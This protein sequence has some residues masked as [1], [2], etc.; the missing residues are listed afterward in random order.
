ME[1]SFWK[2]RWDAGQIGFH[3]GTANRFLVRFADRLVDRLAEGSVFVPLA[4]KTF[5][6]DHLL[7]KGHAVTAVELIEA[8]VTAFFEERKLAPKI[9]READRE[10]HEHEGLT[11]IRGDV[12][13]VRGSFDAVWD[14][15][16]LIA[17]P[18]DVRARYAKHVTSLVRPG[19]TMLLV[20]LEHD[21]GSGPPFEVTPDEVRAHYEAAF[22]IEELAHEDVLTDSP[23]LVQKGA[24][25]V[26]ERAWLLTKKS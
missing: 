19:G 10:V 20:T 24:T 1:R 16:A 7:A 21:A 9:T 25:R 23:S 26:H 22:A 4:G 8:A 6:V 15:A 12:F 2:G 5:D 17:L 3:E 18:P 11:F 13:D 14:R